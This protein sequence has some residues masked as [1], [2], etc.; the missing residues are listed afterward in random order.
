MEEQIRQFCD[1]LIARLEEEFSDSRTDVHVSLDLERGVLAASDD[2]GELF[3]QRQIRSLTGINPDD[4]RSEVSGMLKAD[5]GT[6]RDE[7]EN[8]PLPKPYDI[9]FEL[10]GEEHEE[11]LLTIDSDLIFLDSDL[12]EGLDSDLDTFWQDLSRE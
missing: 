8:L 9:V 5:L 7:L 1:L 4:A 3:V 12:M 2:E 11:N 10:S 6:R